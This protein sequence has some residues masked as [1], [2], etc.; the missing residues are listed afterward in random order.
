MNQIVNMIIRMVMNRLLRR[1]VDAGI[2]RVVGPKPAR[3]DMSPGQRAGA[4]AARATTKRARQAMRL[5]RR[6]GRF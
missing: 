1:G 4:D 3:G 5:V 6:V 2:N